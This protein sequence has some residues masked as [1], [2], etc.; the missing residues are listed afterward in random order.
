MLTGLTD[1]SMKEKRNAALASM[2]SA[3]TNTFPIRL[4]YRCTSAVR[5]ASRLVPTEESSVMMQAPMF[6]PRIMGIAEENVTLPVAESACRM[7]TEA[8]ELWMIAVITAPVS[9]PRIGLSNSVRIRVNSGISASGSTAPLIVCMP[10]MRMEKP[11]R[12]V[13]T[14]LRLLL[15]ENSRKVTPT[16][17]ST[18]EKEE[19]FNS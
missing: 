10:N 11:S 8:E 18:G 19:G 12:I 1:V 5:R 16:I 7:P 6:M 15:L 17:A 4:K 13:P 3:V 2:N 9:T 14:S